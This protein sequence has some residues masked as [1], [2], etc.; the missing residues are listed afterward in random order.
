MHITSIAEETS[1]VGLFFVVVGLLGF[2]W[3]NK[4][5]VYFLSF[6]VLLKKQGPCFGVFCGSFKESSTVFVF[7]LLWLFFLRGLTA[8]KYMYIWKYDVVHLMCGPVYG[9]FCGG[10]QVV[11]LTVETVSVRLWRLS[12]MYFPRSLWVQWSI[13]V[14]CELLWLWVCTSSTVKQLST[15]QWNTAINSTVKQLSTAQWNSCQRH[16]ET[17]L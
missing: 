8:C 3:R 1:A 11:S 4:D 7:R 15:A 16:S 13:D 14:L 17:Q 2:F 6:G 12:V 10:G 9:H 5:C